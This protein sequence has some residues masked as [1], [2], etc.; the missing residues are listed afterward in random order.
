MQ[1]QRLFRYRGQFLNRHTDDCCIAKRGK[2]LAQEQRERNSTFQRWSNL[3]V[4]GP[5]EAA[6]LVVPDAMHNRPLNFP[7]TLPKER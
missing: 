6:R 4:S 7:Q 1:V 5:E 2:Q 3:Q